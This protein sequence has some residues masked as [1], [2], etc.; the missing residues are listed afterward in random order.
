MPTMQ[1]NRRTVLCGGLASALAIPLG[2]RAAPSANESHDL[3]VF[4][5]GVARWQGRTFR[6]ALGHGGVKAAKRE[7][8]GATPEGSWPVRGLLYRADRLAMPRSV[9]PTRALTP[10]DGWCDDPADPSYNRP[11]TLPFR[12][13]A[14]ALWR[15]DHLYDLIVVVG[16]NDDPVVA[17]KGSAIFLHVASAGFGPTAGC[18]AFARDDL[19]ALIAQFAATTRV[20]VSARPAAS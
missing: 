9:L 13:R 17:G 6:C 19:L 16:Y 4:A 2:A 10:A 11:V 8:D 1:L 14:E 12:A 3:L 7:G 5:N 18:I 20:V 15:P